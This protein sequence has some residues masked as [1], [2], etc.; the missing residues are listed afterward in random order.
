MI[1]RRDFITLLGGAAAWPIAARAQQPQRL[2]RIGFVSSESTITES[3]QLVAAFMQGLKETGFSP[4][5]DGRNVTISFIWAGNFDRLT[6]LVADLVHREV[7]VIA[8]SDM[9]AT[10][11][12]QAAT[13]TIPIVW[14][15]YQG[16]N[17]DSYRTAGVYV[18]HILKRP[19]DLPAVPPR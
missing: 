1:H 9:R 15:S 5:G 18:G 13:R 16:S 17:A 19:T 8:A 14:M 10:E 4:L 2:P 7:A 12:A 3:A 11:A 6:N